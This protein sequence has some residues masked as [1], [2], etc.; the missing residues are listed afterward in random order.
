VSTVR[1]RTLAA[2]ALA[3]SAT[4]ILGGCGTGF[5]AQTNQVYQAA[6]GADHRGE[7]D[8]LNTL[9]VA[10][11][12]KSATLS[13]GLINNTDT[14]QSVSAVTATTMDGAKLQVSSLK[15]LLSLPANRFSPVGGATDAGGFRIV[16]SPTPGTYVR[17]TLTFTDSAPVTVEAPIVA[18]TAEYDDV[19]TGATDDSATDGAE[20][21]DA[22]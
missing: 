12:D 18:R 8:V 21:V 6:V 17:V 10:N 2:T 19:A 20:T 7:I 9:L 22:E 5:G 3:A 16:D 1:R 11:D 4:L 13:A 14:E 15:T